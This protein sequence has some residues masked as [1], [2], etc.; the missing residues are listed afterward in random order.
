MEFTVPQFI[1]K[2]A[3]IVGPFTFRQ[4]I[5]I[6]TAGGICL[7]LF[8]V[9]PFFAFIIVAIILLGGALALALLKVGKTSLPV[10]IKNFF[11]F[12]FKPKLYLWKKKTSP[13]KFLGRKKEIKKE[14]EKIE[15]KSKLKVTKGGRLDE[16]F[17]RIETK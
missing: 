9:L 4:F 10:F 3:K 5:F 14:E 8:F 6:G 11:I 1:E 13:P 2:E 12:I 15:K 17:T 7:L 16:L